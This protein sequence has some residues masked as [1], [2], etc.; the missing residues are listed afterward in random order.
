PTTHPEL[1]V[2]WDKLFLWAF[3]LR[4]ERERVTWQSVNLHATSA[5]PG[6]T[7]G[8]LFATMREA[9]ADDDLRRLLIGS[10]Q[11]PPK[12]RDAELAAVLSRIARGEA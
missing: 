10:P 9:L 7:M 4:L 2:A 5:L 1:K 3:R 6:E 12:E 11:A 8:G